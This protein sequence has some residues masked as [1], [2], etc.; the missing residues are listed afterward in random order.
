MSLGIDN[1]YG[2]IPEEDYKRLH[3]K[4]SR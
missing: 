2:K 3:D 4:L 1:V